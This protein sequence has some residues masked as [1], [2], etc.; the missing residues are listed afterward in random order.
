MPDR[1]R[2]PREAR[3]RARTMAPAEPP[4]PA[5]GRAVGPARPA[6]PLHPGILELA[7]TLGRMLAEEDNAAD[8]A[9]NDEPGV[10]CSSPRRVP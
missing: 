1:R 4:A 6:K 10:G 2:R 7:R 9:A 8:A 3:R 5:G